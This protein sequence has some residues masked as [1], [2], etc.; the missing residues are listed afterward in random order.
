MQPLL[1]LR[2]MSPA[3]FVTDL[4]GDDHLHP[5]LERLFERLFSPIVN[6]TNPSN[7]VP[8]PQ[9]TIDTIEGMRRRNEELNKLYDSMDVPTVINLKSQF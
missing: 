5:L 2:N 3:L 8:L 4:I 7:S 9:G 6:Q 1:T